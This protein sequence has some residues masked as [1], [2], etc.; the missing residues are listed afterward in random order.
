MASPIYQVDAFATEPFTGNP[1]GVCLL[2]R[3]VAAEWMQAVAREMAVSAT[4]FAWVEEA[5]VRLRWFTPVAEL[6]LCG[7][8][9]LATAHV[10][11]E[12]EVVPR[13]SPIAFET[14][15]GRLAATRSGDHIELDFPSEP[16]EPEAIDAG[17]LHALGVDSAR[18]VGRNRMDLLVEVDGEERVRELRPVLPLLAEIPARGV[19]VTGRSGSAEY[20]FVSRFFAPAIGVN[21]DPVTGSAHC[22]LGPYWSARLGRSTLTAYQA[23]ERGGSLRVTIDGDRTRLAGRATTVFRGELLTRP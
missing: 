19:I 1:A 4:A 5:P 17:L 21:E 3:D 23:S 2:D 13:G 9:T 6:D 12:E 18:Y 16:P 22:C 7:H 20:D 15:S 8:A 11:W 14:R 10:L